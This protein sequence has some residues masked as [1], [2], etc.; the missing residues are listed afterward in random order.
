MSTTLVSIVSH[1]QL[2]LICEL[3]KDLRAII[4]DDVSVVITINVPE[5]ESCLTQFSDLGLKIIRNESPK[6]FGANHNTAFM[7]GECDYFAVVNPDIRLADFS[8]ERILLRFDDSVGACGPLVYSPEGTL[9][10]SFRHFPTLLDLIKRRFLARH[11]T[12]YH[13]SEMPT[14]VDWLAGMFVI[15][16]GDAFRSVRGFDERYFMYMEDA[17]VCRR[18]MDKGWVTIVD[19]SVSVI[20]DARRASQRSLRHFLWHLRSAFRFLF[21][22]SGRQDGL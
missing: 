5:D 4:S 1:G 11:R 17:D 10:D 13:I 20:H 18:L 9:E 14:Q 8:F 2:S 12:V 7:S 21:G 6:G 3:L 16:R 19:P 22:S 15:F